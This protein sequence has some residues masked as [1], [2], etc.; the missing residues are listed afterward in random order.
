VSWLQQNR[1]VTTIVAL[2]L[3]IPVLLVMYLAGHFWMLR[4]DYQQQI[5][6]LEPRLARLAGLVEVG[7]Q[8][9][10]A[11]TRADAQLAQLVYP[12]SEDEATV[13]ATLQKNVREIMTDAGFSVSDSR[14]LPTKK[15]EVLDQIGVRLTVSGDMAALD[16]V[17]MD[18]AGYTPKLFVQS[19]EMRPNR[20]SKKRGELGGQRVTAVFQFLSLRAIN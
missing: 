6:R 5:D 11:S 2:T 10:A 15:G 18:I 7:D 16:E 8:L 4:H 14:I 3:A 17:L 20:A 12:S 19:A 1:T 9:Q 13:A